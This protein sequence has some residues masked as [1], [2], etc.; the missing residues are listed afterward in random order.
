MASELEKYALGDSSGTTIIKIYL[1]GN[2]LNGLYLYIQ[3]LF[4]SISFFQTISIFSHLVP[5][6]YKKRFNS[7][8]KL[9]MNYVWRKIILT[10]VS[11][12]H[13]STLCNVRNRKMRIINNY[14]ETWNKTTRGPTWYLNLLMKC[15]IWTLYCDKNVIHFLTIRFI[16]FFL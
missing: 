12:L 2:N 8:L 4:L 6:I 16:S 5:S 10:I 14:L 15:I 13:L 7:S 1:I 3:H 11:K 9:R